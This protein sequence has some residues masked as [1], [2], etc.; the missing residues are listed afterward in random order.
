LKELSDRYR[1]RVTTVAL[2]VTD[3]RSIQQALAAALH[4]Y[5][6]ID[7]LVSNAGYRVV[8]A[9]EEVNPDD[10]KRQYDTN[11]FGAINMIRSVLPTM[12]E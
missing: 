2:D 6:R 4:A 1:D 10:I 3:D 9:I 8:G 12:R 11:V 7:V 5:D